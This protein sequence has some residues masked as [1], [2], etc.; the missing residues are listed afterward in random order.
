MLIDV[1]KKG[2]TDRSIVLRAFDATGQP[3]TSL[4]FNSAGLSLWYRREGAARVDMTE[5]T[6]A[7]LSAAHADGGF[8]HVG[9]GYYRID[10]PDAAWATGANYVD[11]G[12]TATGAIFLGG[13]V[14]LVNIDHE[15]AAAFGMSRLDVAASTRA[16]QASVDTVDAVA[17]ATLAS[18]LV[19]EG[20]LTATRAG[21]LD[22]LSGGAVATAAALAA[23]N[24]LVAALENLSAAQVLTQVNA[25]LDAA[26][27][28]SV[29]ADGSRPSLR[30]AA[31]M[32]TQFLIE[33]S[34]VG[35]TVTVRKPDG[36]TTLFTLS[37]NSGTAPTSVTRV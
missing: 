28:D 34:V 36:A 24:A 27:P 22:N 16:S 1:V 11:F 30:Q 21:Y 6:L 23:V 3:L 12:G 25:A 18:A 20:R 37:L 5:V 19:T 14:R 4:V 13:R 7:S 31:Y 15:D 35:T 32:Q 9:D 8:L 2:S 29:P 26:V 17:D 10:I 33:R